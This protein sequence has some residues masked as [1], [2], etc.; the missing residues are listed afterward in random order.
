MPDLKVKLP[1]GTPLGLGDGATGADA[2]AA[3]GPGLAKA[4]LAIKVNGDDQPFEAFNDNTFEEISGTTLLLPVGLATMLGPNNKFPENGAIEL[5]RDVN[6]DV[7][8]TAQS[9]PYLISG[10]VHVDGA[11]EAAPASLSI[12]PGAIVK[13]CVFA[14]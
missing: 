11:S 8:L 2:A 5:E 1:D 12:E 13:F 9:A 3:I 7:V 14:V 10:R 4:A 6:R